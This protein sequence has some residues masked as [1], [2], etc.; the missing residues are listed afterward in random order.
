[1]QIRFR[2][3]R[4][5][6]AIVRLGSFAEAARALHVTPAALSQAI[7]ELEDTL[8]FRLLERTT[9]SLRL[10]EAGRGYLAF[11]QRVVTE[12]AGAE[13]FV[14][15]LRD[16]HGVVRVATTQTVLAT[17]LAAA[18]PEVRAR[19]PRV[20]LHALDV[21]A[22]DIADALARRQ[23]DLAIGVRLPADPQFEGGALFSS[24]WFAF[25]ARGHALG[26]RRRVGWTELAGYDLLMTQTTRLSL[27][28]SLGPDVRLERVG[29]ATTVNAG[30]AMASAGDGA[31]LFP[32]YAQ[33]VARVMGLR[34]VPIDSPDILHVLHIAWARHASTTAPLAAIGGAIA[35]AVGRRCRDLR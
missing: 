7:R 12:L 11:A 22:A 25:V 31:A 33:P 1:M 35:D 32:G 29:D 16:G 4:A 18:L 26:R 28:G 20:R 5:F 17:L 13:R 8:G 23:A 2:Q 6:D 21:A 19:W 24:R 34:P 15:D 30:L 27:Q 10:T 9:R 14:R 3:L